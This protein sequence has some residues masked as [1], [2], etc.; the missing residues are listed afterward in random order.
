MVAVNPIGSKKIKRTLVKRAG[1]SA[2]TASVAGRN[3]QGA[4]MPT[5]E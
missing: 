2:N 5:G 1:R 3:M 4:S